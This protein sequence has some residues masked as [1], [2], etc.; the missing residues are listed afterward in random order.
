M[1]ARNYD[2][3]RSHHLAIRV[4]DE[5]GHVVFEAGF[6]LDAEDAD[7]VTDVLDG[8]RYVV[9]ADCDAENYVLTAC[10]L[11]EYADLL[12]AVGNGVIDVSSHRSV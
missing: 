1:L 11:D 4:Y 7:A 3:S 12:I 9:E 8:G 6:D 10:D 2:Q 5:N